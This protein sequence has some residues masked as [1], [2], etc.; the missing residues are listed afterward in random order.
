MHFIWLTLKEFTNVINQIS[1]LFLTINYENS[2]SWGMMLQLYKGKANFP[3]KVYNIKLFS[4]ELKCKK[5]NYVIKNLE[6]KY[7]HHWRLE[8]R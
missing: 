3:P 4:Q 1:K 6:F 5:Y 8:T 2:I 7:Y